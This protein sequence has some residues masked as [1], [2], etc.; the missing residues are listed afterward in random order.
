MK[1]TK[2]KKRTRQKLPTAKPVPADP[3]KDATGHR[4]F[5]SVANAAAALGLS[6]ETLL[7]AKRAGCPAFAGRGSVK[8]DELLK[9]IEANPAFSLRTLSTK[10]QIELE[11]LRKKR[12][13]NDLAEGKLIPRALVAANLGRIAAHWVSA[14]RQ[15]IEN[16]LPAL[17]LG[18]DLPNSRVKCKQLS[19]ALVQDAR[20]LQ[21]LWQEPKDTPKSGEP[22]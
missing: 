16:E 19:D 22:G 1:P 5:P 20:D 11:D 7:A 21:N 10:G 9:W 2:S 3:V 13:L 4:T 6:R 18:L 12:R 15:K 14:T 17:L 8:E